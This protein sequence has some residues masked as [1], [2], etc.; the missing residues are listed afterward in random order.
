MS[1]RSFLT[2]PSGKPCYL[3]EVTNKT[4]LD[5][6]KYT[7]SDDYCGFYSCLN[8]IIKETVPDFED[9]DIIDK[10]YVYLALCFFSVR[11]TIP[12]KQ[13]SRDGVYF[14]SEVAL[15]VLLDNIE[16][17]YRVRKR[18]LKLSPK[19]R[20]EI[21]YPKALIMDNESIS[22]DFASAISYING[23]F[24]PVREIS[25][26]LTE[27]KPNLAMDI[28][29]AAQEDSELHCN[30]TK[31]SGKAKLEVNLCSPEIFYVI[32][33][34]YKYPISTFYEEM[35]IAVQYM[36]LTMSDFYNMTRLEFNIFTKNFN[37]DKEEQKKNKKQA[38]TPQMEDFLQG[39]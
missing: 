21:G 24:F 20:V 4:F 28:W 14:D 29:L 11:P 8:E 13:A 35:Y 10:A 12:I 30:L 17:T 23:K 34:I 3:N 33:M 18:E 2:T 7:N 36:R 19:V 22:L 38:M 26:F 32:F 5:I 6:I 1:Y 31:N 25:R 39:R 9:F 27:I 37:K 15:S 16:Q